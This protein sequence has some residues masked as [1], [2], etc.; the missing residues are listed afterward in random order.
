MRILV[1]G[2]AGFIGFHL[3]KRLLQLDYDVVGLDTIN[4]YYDIGLKYGR[5]KELGINKDDA[6]IFGKEISSAAFTFIRINLQ[7]RE[8]LPALFKRH[9]FTTVCNLAAQ[10]GVRYSLDNPHS[11]IDSNIS[12]FM[13]LLECCREHNI[14]RLIYASSSS[15][16]GNNNE[17]PFKEDS[18]VDKPI[19][20]YAATKKANELMAHSY[21]HLFG[22]ETVGLRFFTVY[23]PWGR[24]DMAMFLFTK[25]ILEK[26]PIQIF[27]NGD[28]S[29][30]FTYISDVIDGVVSVIE[31][32]KLELEY[33]V[34][35]IGNNK[36]VKLL[37][38]VEALE[39]EL[40][41][42]A[43]KNMLPM[44]DGDVNRTW[45]DVTSLQNQVNYHPKVS[46]EEGI[47]YFVNWYSHYY[48]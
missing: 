17:V 16:Y 7:D 21:S 47:R 33:Q 37:D 38:F 48:K 44:Q 6:E 20:I 27:N 36:P 41:I 10:A 1:T 46:V 3:C 25:A 18:M 9:K 43:L 31:K 2:A 15:V 12:G 24:P 19:S 13:N 39:N 35:N 30:D 22:L 8:Q 42:K 23:G 28:L 34:F 14:K 40:G 29:R 4:D 5:L 32:E 45:A 11:Y 26:Q